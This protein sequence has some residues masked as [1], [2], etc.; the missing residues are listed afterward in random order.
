[1]QQS[2]LPLSQ[3]QLNKPSA[4][5]NANWCTLTL[6]VYIGNSLCA[7]SVGGR[8]KQIPTHPLHLLYSIC[9]GS[10]SFK[11]GKTEGEYSGLL[12]VWLGLVTKYP[13]P[14]KRPM[15]AVMEGRSACLVI[16]VGPWKKLPHKMPRKI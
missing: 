1:V 14:T 8:D 15:L 16:A 4:P 5:P 6:L 9:S 10:S 3:S 7:R 11:G 13:D 2:I 12:V